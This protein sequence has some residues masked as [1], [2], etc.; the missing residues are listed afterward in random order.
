MKVG[1]SS[2]KCLKTFAISRELD[3]H[4]FEA[5]TRDKNK[6]QECEEMVSIVELLRKH[7]DVHAANCL[8]NALHAMSTPLPSLKFIW[9]GQIFTDTPSKSINKCTKDSETSS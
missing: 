2:V 8:T 9:Q 5:H 7:V 4:K 3:D 1:N 6:C